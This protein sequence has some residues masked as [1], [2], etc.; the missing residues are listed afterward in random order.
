MISKDYSKRR[1]NEREPYA[2]EKHKQ[3]VMDYDDLNKSFGDLAPHISLKHKE[4]TIATKYGL[5]RATI[6][7]VLREQYLINR[8]KS[9]N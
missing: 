5:S 8:K 9:R 3:I 4:D 1:S 7:R 6:R 2:S